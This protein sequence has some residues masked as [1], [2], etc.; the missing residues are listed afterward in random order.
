MTMDEVT[1]L[2]LLFTAALLALNTAAVVL[3]YSL[4]V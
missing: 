1:L 2:Y 3:L 4:L